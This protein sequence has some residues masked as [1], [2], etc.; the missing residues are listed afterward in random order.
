MYLF[1]AHIAE[2]ATGVHT[3]SLFVYS[4]L[5]YFNPG[6]SSPTLECSADKVWPGSALSK[7]LRAQ[8]GII[9]NKRAECVYSTL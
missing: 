7:P 8:F 4:L 3:V 1:M 6:M 5:L 9:S 2:L